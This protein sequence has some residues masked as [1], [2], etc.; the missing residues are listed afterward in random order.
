MV[1][2]TENTNESIKDPNA[3]C[4]DRNVQCVI[5]KTR[6]VQTDH[7]DDNYEHTDMNNIEQL[8]VKS[9]QCK[10]SDDSDEHST[11]GDSA[12]NLICGTESFYTACL[13]PFV[14]KDGDVYYNAA[15]GGVTGKSVKNV[16][17]FIVVAGKNSNGG[18]F[19]G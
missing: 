17:M 6:A 13:K 18:V 4:G 5:C 7:G 15:E 12:V 14:D 8:I 9:L 1:E 2:D 3:C 11:P 10:C 16:E 19:E